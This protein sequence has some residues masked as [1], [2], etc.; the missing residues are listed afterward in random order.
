MIELGRSPVLAQ[1]TP[2][3]QIPHQQRPGEPQRLSRLERLSEALDAIE[4]APSQGLVELRLW[5]KQSGPELT[6]PTLIKGGASSSPLSLQIGRINATKL[7]TANRKLRGALQTLRAVYADGVVDEGEFLALAELRQTF[8]GLLELRQDRG[9]AGLPGLHQ[10]LEKELFAPIEQLLAVAQGEHQQLGKMLARRDLAPLKSRLEALRKTGKVGKLLSTLD[11]HSATLET[12]T[13]P[14]RYSVGDFVM[15]PRTQDAPSLGV[16]VGRE[17]SGQLRV[18]FPVGD[19]L[20]T[21]S[22]SSQDLATYNPL[23]IGDYLPNLGGREVWVNG[24]DARGR[25][26]GV[27]RRNGAVRPLDARAISAVVAEVHQAV[28]AASRPEPFEEISPQV[29]LAQ[30]ERL[31]QAKRNASDQLGWDRYDP[32]DTQRTIPLDPNV[33]AAANQAHRAAVHRAQSVRDQL[34]ALDPKHPIEAAKLKAHGEAVEALNEIRRGSSRTIQGEHGD[35]EE[36]S[37]AL[38][39]WSRAAATVDGW[40]NE[41]APLTEDGVITQLK[42]LSRILTEGILLNH[43][44]RGTNGKFRGPGMDIRNGTGAYHPGALVDGSLKKLARYVVE[45][46]AEVRAGRLSLVEH[47]GRVLNGLLTIH[48]PVDGNGRMTRMFIDYLAQRHG[49]PPLAFKPE[50]QAKANFYVRSDG[51]PA[52]DPSIDEAV[53]AVASALDR[54]LEM[55]ERALETKVT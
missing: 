45:G 1:K 43:G 32:T 15:V 8:K 48:A 34:A 55:Q 51:I 17:A 38:L 21:K 13:S 20:G 46:D 31:A 27:E 24:A 11:V 37:Q 12:L 14:S 25:L 22:M 4:D 16:V 19:H 28:S 53:A 36:A 7:A 23:R 10:K 26:T 49:L 44:K 33:R 6:P 3:L 18:E 2:E 9:L 52:N 29:Y 39:N 50:E 35:G 47:L 42:T 54:A 40:R 5:M 41:G 30:R